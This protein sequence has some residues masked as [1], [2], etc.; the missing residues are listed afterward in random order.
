MNEARTTSILQR[1]PVILAVTAA[2]YGLPLHSQNRR[3]DLARTH[4]SPHRERRETPFDRGVRGEV[5]LRH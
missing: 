4:R 2:S 1:M 3:L 5:A